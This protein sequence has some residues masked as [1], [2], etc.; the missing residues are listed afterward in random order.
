MEHAASRAS[1]MPLGT[2]WICTKL[3]RTYYKRLRKQIVVQVPVTIKGIC[4][5]RSTYEIRGLVPINK[6][7]VKAPELAIDAHTPTRNR[8]AKQLVMD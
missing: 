3:G 5:D 1:G 6:M 2:A 7:C 8:K 4:K